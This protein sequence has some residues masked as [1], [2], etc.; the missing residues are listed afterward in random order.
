[1]YVGT[2]NGHPRNPLYPEDRGV[3]MCFRESD[4]AFLWQL[5]EPK[6][7]RVGAFN[8]DRPGV[9]ICSAPAVEGNR[10]Y[11][12]T[13]RGEILCLDTDGLRN[14]NHGAF[15]SERAVLASAS[16]DRVVP[17]RGGPCQRRT[18][19]GGTPLGLTDAD[20]IWRF[21]MIA[22]VDSWPQD[23]VC[24][25][26]LLI[27][28]LLWVGTSTGI[29]HSSG[30]RALYPDA[31][32]LIALDKR[33]GRLVA[34]D[35]ERIGAR[36]WHGQW[37]SP[38][39]GVVGG[40]PLVFYG[41]GDGVCYA[42]DARPRLEAGRQVGVLRKVWWFDCNPAS[43][44]FRDGMPIPYKTPGDGPSEIIATPV[45]HANRVYVA[46]GQDPTHGP[47]RGCLSCIDATG[48]GDISRSGTVWQYLNIGR[49]VS[50][51]AAAEGRVYAADYAGYVHCLD[52]ATGR[53]LWI[54]D[55]EARVWASPLVVDGKVFVGTE[56]GDMWILAAAAVKTVLGKGHLPGPI[57]AT[58]T[59]ANGKLFV[60]TRD[61]LYA[62]VRRPGQGLDDLARSRAAPVAGRTVPFV[63]LDPD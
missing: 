9:G 62:A 29:S 20:I 27:G 19:M 26:P 40:L 52:A 2:N 38:A 7:A 59:A 36:T 4:G 23:A 44:R 33:S 49:S 13:N 5:A 55:T 22:E 14:G 53:P 34:V 28:D 31:P 1:V 58:P 12:V 32:S 17:G 18:P 37:S 8:G 6:I 24:S 41:G 25:S 21:D 50:T 48:E 63:D 60:A 45:F 30:R 15:T 3:L 61:R 11:V 54:H 43:L 16:D 35:H 51:V 42:F 39:Y 56:K 57:Y 47:G 10:L 46:V